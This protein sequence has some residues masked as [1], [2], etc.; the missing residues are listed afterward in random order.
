[1]LNTASRSRPASPRRSATSA[2]RPVAPAARAARAAAGVRSS[3]RSVGSKTYG[4]PNR[5]AGLLVRGLQAWLRWQQE[6]GLAE[7]QVRCSNLWLASLPM[8]ALHDGA[9][10]SKVRSLTSWVDPPPRTHT[11]T[12]TPARS[13]SP[14]PR[15]GCTSAGLQWWP[16]PSSGRWATA[17]RSV[18]GL[19]APC[20]PRCRRYRAA[21]WPPPRPWTPGRSGLE[22][23]SRARV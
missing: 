1:V 21:R 16:R 6:R 23:G 5:Q 13:F 10:C 18:C 19:P 4:A 14:A 17:T 11:H 2:A 15:P 9:A 12:G 3:D 7:G 20:A 22:L 8:R